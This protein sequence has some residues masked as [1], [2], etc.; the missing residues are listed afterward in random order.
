MLRKQISA[1]AIVSAAMCLCATAAQAELRVMRATGPSAAAYRPGTRLPDNFVFNL[2][3]GDT[4]TLLATGRGQIV[5]KGP[6]RGTASS[7]MARPEPPRAIG[8]VNRG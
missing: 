1:L 3:P 4:L 5:L 6:G 8:R 2:R 7:L